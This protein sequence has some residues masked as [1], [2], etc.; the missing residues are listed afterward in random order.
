MTAILKRG[1]DVQRLRRIRPPALSISK[2]SEISAGVRVLSW[3]LG[4]LAVLGLWLVLFGLVLSGLSESHAQ[5]SLYASFRKQLAAATAPIG[6]AIP[7]GAPVAVLD[8]A[9]G[10]LHGLVVVEGSSSTDLRAGPGHVPGAPLPGQAGVSVIMGRSTTFGAPFGEITSLVRGDPIDVTTGQ[11]IFHYEVED[12][13]GPGDPFPA[14]LASG[15]SQLTLVTSQ[16]A[17]WRTGWAP[18]RAVFVD[19]LL[20]GHSVAA[21]VNQNIPTTADGVQHG[22]SRGLY[23][24]VLWLQLLLIAVV[25]AVWARLRWGGRQSWVV[26]TPVIVA[27]LWGASTSM[28]QL[29]PNLM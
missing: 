11:G 17:G 27:A 28:W 20:M 5:H 21:P 12:V 1:L 26:A 3:T 7:E 25:G 2:G 15:G 24:L 23:P 16:G 14:T 18:S 9:K 29:L 13:R 4:G 8:S 10:G 6:G 22:D 19:A